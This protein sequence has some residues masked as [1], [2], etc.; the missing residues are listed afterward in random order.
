MILCSHSNDI[1][2]TQLHRALPSIN[3]TSRT[4]GTYAEPFVNWRNAS[5][6]RANIILFTDAISILFSVISRRLRVGSRSSAGNAF[7]ARRHTLIWMLP[8]Y[9]TIYNIYVFRTSLMTEDRFSNRKQIN[10]LSIWP[11]LYITNDKNNYFITI[12]T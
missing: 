1:N 11:S 7:Y 5:F 4:V 8:L 12:N 2:H 6:R 10:F 9:Q 3:Y